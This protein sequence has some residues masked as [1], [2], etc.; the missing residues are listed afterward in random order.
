[1]TPEYIVDKFA[2]ALKRFE[3]IDIQ[4][5]ETNL[6]QIWEFLSPILLQNP[7][8]ETEGTQNF[9]GLIWLVADYTT[10]YG[11]EFAEPECVG[12]YYETIDNYATAVVRARTEAAHKAKRAEI[13]T[14]ETAWCETA[15]FILTVTE[16][17]W[18][19]EI[20]Y[21]EKFYTNVAPKALLAHP[22][23]G[24]NGCYTLDLL[25]LHNE[26]QLY[27]L[28]VEGIPEYINMLED[29]QKLAE[30]S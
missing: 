9:I 18:V 29:A 19:R 15:Q 24:C 23:A 28:E 16:D 8:D 5:S 2:Y 21:L 25:E 22:Q 10:R 27:H 4:T 20:R 14:Y 13:G 26:I 30:R 7:Y 6:T 1:M 17:T 3:P 11:A 12:A